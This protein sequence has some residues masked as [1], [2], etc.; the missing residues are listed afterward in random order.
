MLEFFVEFVIGFH[1]YDILFDYSFCMNR[2]QLVYLEM[3][4]LVALLENRYLFPPWELNWKFY[5]VYL[6]K[7]VLSY[8]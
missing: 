3:Q 8:K 7:Q 1:I 6:P 2:V 5:F 4:E